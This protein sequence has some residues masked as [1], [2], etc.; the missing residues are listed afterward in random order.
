[1]EP[2]GT[3]LADSLPEAEALRSPWR[4]RPSGGRKTPV[5]CKIL[6]DMSV[7]TQNVRRTSRPAWNKLIFWELLGRFTA[8]K[9]WLELGCG[10]GVTD[11]G[12]LSARQETHEELYV[13]LDADWS[14]LTSA[15]AGNRVMADAASLPFRDGS[16]DV[17]SSDMVFEHLPR[18][19]DVLHES[20][21]V[22]RNRGTLVVHTSAS[23][24]YSLVIGR[25]LSTLLPRDTYVRLVSRFTGRSEADIFPTR[26]AANTMSKFGKIAYEAGF[27]VGFTAALETPIPPRSGAERFFRRLV[28]TLM[29]S[30]ILA[31]Y[32]KR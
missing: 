16:F 12:L 24:H 18:P 27:E 6:Y 7:A 2:G 14:S 3:C 1:M 11:P 30:T 25:V 5:L 28:P 17:V 31:V 15:A 10:R 22:L 4:H 13:G 9:R 21:R 32:L 26:Y 8:G 20:W 23:L 29:K 19:G